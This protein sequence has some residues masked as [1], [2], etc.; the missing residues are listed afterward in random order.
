MKFFDVILIGYEE[1]ENLGL[2]YIASFLTKNGKSVK[3][4]PYEKYSREDILNIVIQTSPKVIGFSLIFQRMLPEFE[5]LISYLRQNGVDSHFTIGGHFPTVEPLYTLK[6]IPGL[7]SVIRCEGEE[8]LNELI[9]KLDLHEQWDQI[10]GV[11]FRNNGKNIVNPSRPLMVNLDNLPFPIREKSFLSQRG[12]NLCSIIASRGCYYNCSFCSIQK[13]YNEPHGPKRR[14][15]SPKNVVQEMEML[16]SEYGVRIFIFEDDDIVMRGYKQKEWIY[17]MINQLK[18]KKIHNDI[19]WRISCRIDDINSELLKRMTDVG[20]MCVYTGIESGSTEGLKIYN[21]HY[22]ID[23]VYRSLEIL[24]QNEISFEF[25]FML[26]HPYSNF[27]LIKQDI[28][29]L[30]KMRS[31]GDAVVHFTKM[32]PYA[33]TPIAD[34]LMKEGRLKKPIHLPDY[35]YIDSKLSLLQHF[36]TE[37]F[38]FRNFDR[39]GLVEQLRYAKFDSMVA[40]KF[41]SQSQNKLN[42]MNTL[43]ELIF[44]CNDKCLETMS[45]AVNLMDEY[46]EFDILKYWPLLDHFTQEEKVVES[47]I[48]LNLRILMES[49]YVSV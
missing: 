7:N 18:K 42:Y 1:V 33:G 16:F 44:Q 30:K 24:A 38:H 2:R 46:S 29:F 17:E 22:T 31:F 14:T 5:E 43:K 32:V 21:K 49:N 39:N 48:T 23:D 40:N 28:S 6:S 37:A 12:I 25:G 27:D 19:L 13:F 41:F 3:I 26:L 34:K 4:I 15:R 20:L 47:Q 11:A 45:K 36:F 9:D 10:R 35:D 8:T